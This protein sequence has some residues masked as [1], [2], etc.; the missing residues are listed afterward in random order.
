MKNKI[1]RM[2]RIGYADRI[3]TNKNSIFFILSPLAILSILLFYEIH[4]V[5][6]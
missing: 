6:L 4:Y 2:D 5:G 1:S 3:K